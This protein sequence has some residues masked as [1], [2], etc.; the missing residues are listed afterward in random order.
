MNNLELLPS[1]FI[2]IY[3]VLFGLCAGSFLNVAIIRG[4]AG[5]ELIFE[6]SHCPECKNK[7]KWY[8]NIPLLSY[9]FLGGKCAFC[10]CKISIQ[11]PIVEFITALA[12]VLSYLVFGLTLKT[13]FICIFFAL[14]ILMSATDFKETV[15]IDTHAYILLV[16]GLLYAALGLGEINVNFA[17]LGAFVGFVFF[18]V[19]AR[20]GLLIA[21][22]R[23]FGE[24]DSLIALGLGA[25]FG[26]KGLMIVIGLSILI[27]AFATIP[28]LIVKSFKENN[29]KLS[30]SYF[31]VALS[32][33]FLTLMNEFNLIENFHLYLSLTV[34]IVIF[35]LWAL[36]NIL[37]EIKSKK[38]DDTKNDE[39]KFCL[40]P[41][42]PALL[43]SATI[44]IFY[45]PQ[46]KNYI[47][48]F[49]K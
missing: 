37:V 1:W 40:L 24:G 44:Y 12:F 27:Q 6:R 21:G 39:E 7:L 33:I 38:L 43:I 26:W 14:F 32:V 41:F 47:L 30:F 8:M 29:K 9:L 2:I 5:K 10:K 16:F 42:G 13:L 18:E 31:L 28:F 45:L 4:L 25:I 15:I 46:I 11:Y 49:I 23:M 3:V 19:M 48:N 22:C 34:F 17:L 36:K 20:I 35:L